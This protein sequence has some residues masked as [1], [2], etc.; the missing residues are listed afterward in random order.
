MTDHETVTEQFGERGPVFDAALR[1][2]RVRSG[3]ALR[4]G[5]LSKRNALREIIAVA[6]LA[7]GRGKSMSSADQ[8]KEKLRAALTELRDIEH[9]RL[10]NAPLFAKRS[11]RSIVDAIKR[12][13]EALAE[14]A[15]GDK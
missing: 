12:A 2:I 3:T 1:D 9:E 11:I 6:Q 14:S 8:N 13:D 10:C 7:L 15:N 5:S 4:Q